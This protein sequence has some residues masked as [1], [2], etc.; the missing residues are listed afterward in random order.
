MFKSTK[1]LIAIALY[2]TVHQGCCGITVSVIKV[3]Q[4]SDAQET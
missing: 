1:Y 4:G 2:Q 3:S